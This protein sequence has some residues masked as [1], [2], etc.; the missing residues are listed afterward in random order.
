MRTSALVNLTSRLAAFL[1]LQL[2]AVQAFAQDKGLNVDVDINDK[3]GGG[4]MSNIWIWVGIAAFII[5]LVLAMRAGGS[6]SKE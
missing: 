1:T 4:W 3:S 2:L 6:T 5:I